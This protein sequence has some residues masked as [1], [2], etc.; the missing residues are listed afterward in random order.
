ME[1]GPMY[2]G[3]LLIVLLAALVLVLGLAFLA[4]VLWVWIGGVRERRAIQRCLR[5]HGHGAKQGVDELS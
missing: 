1:V 5:I 3:A 2:L 4:A